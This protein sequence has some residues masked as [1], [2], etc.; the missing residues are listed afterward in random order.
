MTAAPWRSEDFRWMTHA[1]TLAERGRRRAHPN[2][3]VGCV[4]V[5]GGRS[6]GEGAHEVFGGPHAEAVALARAGA[7]ARGA[8]MY[9]TLEP[10]AHWGKTPPC[11]EA[12]A[13]AGLRRVIA[14]AGDPNRRVRGRGFARLRRSGIVV[15]TGLLAESARRQNAAFFK[16][17][18]E[19]IPYLT[20]KIAQTLD[21]R[22]AAASGVSRWITGPQS[23]GLGHVLRAQ[24]DAVLVGGETVRRDDPGLTAHGAG[25]D[26]LRLVL[27]AS[28]RLPPRAKVFK[29]GPPTWVLTDRRA[30]P[31]LAAALERRGVQV[32]RAAGLR[33]HFAALAKMGVTRVLCEG[34]G[35]TA[36]ALLEAGLADEAYVFISPQF[37]GGPGKPA[38]AGRGWPRPGSGPR[39]KETGVTRLGEDVLMHG[40]FR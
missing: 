2:P 31:A 38:V 15:R 1:F 30:S 23:R 40:Y 4:I 18:R 14:A 28:L 36:A 10:C 19:G 6:V 29:S 13:A 9:V 20:L 16:V 22:I 33:E 32:L 7:R 11:A 17:H 25:P 21:G 8:T 5:K 3:L 27:S 12:V 24:A 34:G 37:L 26:P 35:A 39:L